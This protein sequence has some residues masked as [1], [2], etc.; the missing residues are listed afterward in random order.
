MKKF[1]RRVNRGI[2]LAV[3]LVIG[4]A[5]YVI[6][7]NGHFKASKPDIEKA[8]GDYLAKVKEINLLPADKKA[9]QTLDVV[10]QY[11]CDKASNYTY[12]FSKKD[13]KAYLETV[14]KYGSEQT[15]L[16]EYNEI[17][18]DMTVLKN[19]PGCARVTVSYDVSMTMDKEDRDYQIFGLEADTYG[20]YYNVQGEDKLVC[21]QNLIL[22]LYLYETD[23]TWKIGSIDAVSDM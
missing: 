16:T 8:A 20:G 15:T 2:L 22:T 3:V 11:W 4:V 7:D 21:S 14:K 17:I 23:G 13:M 18:R 12:G 5:V 10:E 1:L 9:K 19:G 6:A